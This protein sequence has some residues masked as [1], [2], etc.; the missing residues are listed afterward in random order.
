[1]S[2]AIL[3]VATAVPPHVYFQAEVADKLVDILA[4]RPEKESIIKEIYSNS[5]IRKRHLIS[6][7]FHKLREEW[8]FWPSD[9]PHTAPGMSMRNELYKKEALPLAQKAAER[10]LEC[11]GGSRSRITHLISISC[12]GVL[13]PGLEFHLMQ[14]LGLSPSVNRLGINFMGCFGAFKG[15]ST[16]RAFARENY[17][18]RILVVCTELCSLHLQSDQ[19][20]D[21]FVGHSLFADGAAAVII[22]EEPQEGESPLWEIVKTHSASLPQTL[23]L[24]TWEASDHGFVMRLSP[25]VPV[26][27]KR[28]I[29]AF[30]DELKD[31]QLTIQECDW[32]IH[33]GG[34]AIVQ[35]VERALSLDPSQTLST[36]EILA[37]YG[38]M[39]SATF[40]FVLEHLTQ[41][42]SHR[43]WSI[44]IAFGPGLSIEGLLLR[45]F[46]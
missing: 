14:T 25:K 46:R 11:W 22:G 43:E 41:H 36:W 18:H 29:K 34:K 1:M 27:I 21:A 31:H 9:Y 2:A 23:D 5:A 4:I 37:N 20:Y 8:N 17:Q 3:A 32:A 10:A 45:R 13:A 7:D 24:M 35:A 12:T 6:G 44:G 40:L 39:S 15:L 28:H 42:S 30:I 38:N 19:T 16:A 33:P 26:F